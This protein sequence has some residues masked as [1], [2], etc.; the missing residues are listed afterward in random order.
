[1]AFTCAISNGYQLESCSLSTGGIKCIYLAPWTAATYTL[2]V[3][4]TVNNISGVTF[5][6]FECISETAEMSQKA[7]PNIQNQSL[8]YEQEVG[9]IIPKQSAAKRNQYKSLAGSGV[10]MITE[11]RQGVLTLIGKTQSAFLIDGAV[12]AGKAAG[13]FNGYTLKFQAKEPEPGFIVSATTSFTYT[14]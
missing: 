3:D 8:Y 4:D 5:Y 14:Y 9:L 13:D 7:V 12:N 10:L 2:A 11:D 1:M 6:K